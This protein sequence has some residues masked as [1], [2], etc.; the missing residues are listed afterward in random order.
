MLLALLGDFRTA[1]VV[2]RL[3]VTKA[4]VAEV[5]DDRARHDMHQVLD[6]VV[7]DTHEARGVFELAIEEADGFGH[8]RVRNAHLLLGLFRYADGLASRVLASTGATL[9]GARHEVLEFL[10]EDDLDE[11]MSAAPGPVSRPVFSRDAAS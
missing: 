8:L 11:I 2:S 3:G 7:Q 9:D 5:I 1:D 4:D 10:A 6:G